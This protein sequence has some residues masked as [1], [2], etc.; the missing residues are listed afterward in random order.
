MNE[1]RKL[2]QFVSETKFTDLPAEVVEKCKIY[3]LDSLACG[4]LGSV[5]PW[6]K[7]VADLTHEMGGHKEASIFNQSWLTDVSR[8]T[9]VNGVMIGAYEVEH[10]GHLSH[11]SGTVFPAALAIAERE[12][13][14]GPS[15]L[16]AL[17]LGYEVVCRI[18]EAQTMRVE[19]E[20]GFHSPAI[21]GPFGAA[22]TAGKLLDFNVENLTH[23][24]GIAGSH[25]SGL[26]EFA[27]EG[28]MTKRLHL[29]RA[30]QL[31][32]ESA[33]LAGSGFTGPSTILEGRYG[34]L[35][36]YSPRPQLDRLLTDLGEDWLLLT[37]TMKTYC[38]H[39]HCQA[40]VQ[41]IQKFKQ[42][43]DIDPQRITRVS[44]IGNSQLIE[45]R[46]LDTQPKTLLGAQYSIPFTVAVALL[47]DMDNPLVYNEEVLHD[48]VVRQLASKVIVKEDAKRFG[49]YAGDPSVEIIIETEGKPKIISVSELKGSVRQP[50]TFAETCVKFDNYTPM[51]TEKR[52]D[53]IK[54]SVENL[55][56]LPDTA[57]LAMLIR[58]EHD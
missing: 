25:S 26:I 10:I 29:G 15:F 9:L 41:G 37:L 28:A 49:R 1:T 43:E 14:D 11:P 39:I 44:I 18:G 6:A 42:T 8:A 54:S 52:R 46:H 22:L 45:E 5:T 36:A 58:A 19:K 32:L 38:C 7:I 12:H 16:L 2:A 13:R 27:W 3:V 57:A 50:Y 47:N 20:R 56:N 33:L 17:A 34:Y 23:A 48:P 55:S 24:M 4:F 21:N 40:I 30:A 35:Q 51:L 31:G 53:E